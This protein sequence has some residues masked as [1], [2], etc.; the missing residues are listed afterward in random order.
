MP[1]P[2]TDD[3]DDMLNP[4]RG[5][6]DNSGNVAADQLRLLIERVENSKRRR[7][8][9]PTTSRMSTER[10]RPR[11]STPRSCARSSGSVRWSRPPGKRWRPCSTPIRLR[12]DSERK[13]TRYY[14]EAQ[15]SP[16]DFKTELT[17]GKTAEAIKAAAASK[18]GDAIRVPVSAITVI[19]GYNVRVRDTDAY[20]AGIEELKNSIA[21][22]GFYAD[23]P[24]GVYV[25]KD[26]DKNV[27]YLRSGHRR[28]EA[29][30][31]YNFEAPANS[32]I[33]TL[34]AIIVPAATTMEEHLVELVQ[35][36]AGK[37][38][39]PYE[40]GIVVKRLLN[41]GVSKADIAKKLGFTPRYIDDLLVIVGAPAAARSLI[42][43]NK[44]SSTQ[45]LR[46]LRKDPAKAAAALTE[47]VKKAEAKG[48]PKGT[49]KHA[50][51]K[52]AKT[53]IEVNFGKGDVMGATL[54]V[55]AQAVREAVPHADDESDLIMT[56]G[57]LA[58]TI[59]IVPLVEEKPAEEPKPASKPKRA[60][61]KKDA[62][63]KTLKAAKDANLVGDAAP[64][65][66]KGGE[67]GDDLLAHALGS[68]K[69]GSPPADAEDNLADL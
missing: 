59:A 29:V 17:P 21:E 63:A 35:G 47:M 64:T 46:E 57:K 28:L 67:E 49:A 16:A 48:K 1:K 41:F 19:P 62:A 20:K 9:S 2:K 12:W 27:L 7:K 25:G 66:K 11:V 69:D 45:A 39:T 52:M 61:A 50:G 22:N 34:P 18:I 31:A 8:A 32:K 38:L 51:P 58:L 3:D 14:G 15:C 23:K 40:K 4:D 24:L 65:A 54:K 42:L 5:I 60:A 56:D 33:E 10:P 53:Q 68:D 30:E 43:E 13:E 44:V 26:G 37:D 36:N 55:L 6:G